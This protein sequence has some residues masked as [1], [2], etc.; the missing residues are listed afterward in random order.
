MTTSA[1]LP[2][3]QL[4]IA[5]FDTSVTALRARDG[6][7]FLVITE[8]CEALQLNIRTQRRAILA[9]TRLAV[10]PFRL[11]AGNQIQTVE[12]IRLD[13]IPLWLITVRPRSSRETINERLRYVQEY[14]LTS[15]RAAFSA[16][17]QL[18]IRSSDVEDLHQLD[19]LGTALDDIQALQQRQGEL[20][21]LSQQLLSLIRQQDD[22]TQQIADRVQSLERVTAQALTGEQRN[23]LHSLI[24]TYGTARAAIQNRETGVAIRMCW[25]EFNARFRIATYTDLP[26]SRFDEAVRY[27]KESYR[28]LTGKDIDAAT[29]ESLV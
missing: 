9:D 6:V 12:A 28:A 16:L 13:D 21:E 2:T 25:S 24:R 29:Q 15:V 3:E 4:P 1:E 26:A 22:R 10:R 8:L 5:L 19:G 11:R 7:I 14:L 20:E 23:T 17:T 18:P 27:L